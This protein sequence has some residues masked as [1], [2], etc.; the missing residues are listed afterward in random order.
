MGRHATRSASHPTRTASRTKASLNTT[1]ATVLHIAIPIAP[2][3]PPRSC[4][5]NGLGKSAVPAP[6]LLEKLALNLS[7]VGVFSPAA[8]ELLRLFVRGC[9]SSTLGA[10]DAWGGLDQRCRAG[11]AWGGSSLEE[12][13]MEGRGE[14]GGRS[15]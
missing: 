7:I 13:G 15:G 1:T 10:T 2:P 3:P 9:S 5:A 14:R 12:G 8:S 6:F 4:S 11:E